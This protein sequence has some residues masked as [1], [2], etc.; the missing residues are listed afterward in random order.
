MRIFPIITA[1][2]VCVAL[3][4]LILDRQTLLDFAARFGAADTT[5]QAADPAQATATAICRRND[6]R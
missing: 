6:C 2:L 5:E 3:Y 4:F 1:T